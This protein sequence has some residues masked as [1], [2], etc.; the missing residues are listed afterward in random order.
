MFRLIYLLLRDSTYA[1]CAK[2]TIRGP[3]QYGKVTDF[4]QGFERFF[5]K[6]P[7]FPHVDGGRLTESRGL[8]AMLTDSHLSVI[9]IFYQK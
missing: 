4:F 3:F 5:T 6:A 8:S 2:K 7:Y 1:I 9:P